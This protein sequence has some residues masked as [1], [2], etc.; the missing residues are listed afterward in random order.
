[1]RLVLGSVLAM[2]PAK[3]AAEVWAALNDRQRAYMRA[4]YHKDQEAEQFWK[5]A[6]ARG[7]T[8]PPA[9]QWRWLDYGPVGGAS[10]DHGAVRRATDRYQAKK[11]QGATRPFLHSAAR[12]LLDEHTALN[13]PGTGWDLNE[14]RH[15]V[16]A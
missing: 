6:R 10:A 14:F 16:T 3:R 4:I 15:F 2:P 7:K 9:S 11:L 1:M 13:G 5:G 12:A 8:A